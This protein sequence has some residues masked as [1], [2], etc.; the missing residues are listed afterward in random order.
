MAELYGRFIS[1]IFKNCQTVFQS[2]ILQSH[3][4]CMRVPLFLA[5]WHHLVWSVFFFFYWSIVDLQHYIIFRYSTVI[6]L[7]IFHYRLLQ[8][9]EYSSLC[10]TIESDF[11]HFSCYSG[12]IVTST[13]DFNVHFPNDKFYW[14]FFHVLICHSYIFFGEMSFN[15][16]CPLF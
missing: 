2:I 7:H 11:L 8:D 5:S 12:Y 14:A 1:S 4:Q 15:I 16:F 3:Q 9:I 10:C 6:Q 13:W